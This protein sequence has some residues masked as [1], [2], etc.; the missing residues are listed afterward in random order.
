MD[1]NEDEE[2]EEEEEEEEEW[3]SSLPFPFDKGADLAVTSITRG[4]SHTGQG[5]DP[6]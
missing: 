6:E 1:E 3:V 2:D 4:A 5:A